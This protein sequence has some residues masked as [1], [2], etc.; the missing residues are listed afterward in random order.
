MEKGVQTSQTASSGNDYP[1]RG[2]SWWRG[3]NFH[4][5]APQ[6][7]TSPGEASHRRVGHSFTSLAPQACVA[8]HRQAL[9]KGGAML[10]VWLLKDCPVLERS[11]ME[12]GIQLPWPGSPGPV[13]FWGVQPLKLA[14][15]LTSLEVS[16]VGI[17]GRGRANF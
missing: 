16:G 9:G 5:L 14:H 8:L 2:V 13:V 4:F 11:S 6:R 3:H 12:E 1:C 15:N 10:W 17:H 7:L